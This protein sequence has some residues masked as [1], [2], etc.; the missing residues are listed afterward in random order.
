LLV[1]TFVI[2]KDT[3]TRQIAA[4]KIAVARFL[5]PPPQDRRFAGGSEWRFSGLALDHMCPQM[6][7]R[8]TGLNSNCSMNIAEKLPQ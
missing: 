7:A 4:A 6:S 1:S 5:R 2:S 3:K 8:A